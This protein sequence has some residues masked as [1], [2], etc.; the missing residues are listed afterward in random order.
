MIWHIFKKDWKLLWKFAAMMAI[1]QWANAVV[2]VKL[3][4]FAES[5]ALRNL[6]QLLVMAMLAG[7]PFLIA[8]VVHQDPIPGVRQDW[9]VRPIRRKDLLL[10]KFLFVVLAVHG[11]MLI[12]DLGRCLAFGFSFGAS[13]GAAASHGLFVLLAFSVPLF[14][15]AALTRNT[16]EAITAGLIVFLSFAAFALI[17]NGH[18]ILLLSGLSWIEATARIL[19]ALA[20]GAAIL[21]V[22]YFRR[23]TFAARGL[24]AAT[25]LVAFMTFFL[26]WN[27]AFAIEQRMSPDPA[28]GSTIAV[29]FDPSM[30]RF[31]RSASMYSGG[32]LAVVFLPLR[33]ENLPVGSVLLSDRAEVRGH[34]GSEL[35][36][37]IASLILRQEASGGTPAAAHLVVNIPAD[38][39]QGMQDQPGEVE[40]RLSLT[41]FR[42]AGLHTIPALNGRLHAPDL[43][44]CFTKMNNAETAIRLGCVPLEDRP[45][46]AT[47]RLEHI[48]SGRSNPPQFQCQGSYAPFYDTLFVE[49][50]ATG[51]IPFRDLSGLA[52]YPVDGSQLAESHVVIETFQPVDHFTRTVVIPSLRLKDW[53]AQ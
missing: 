8:A 46:C 33:F 45:S 35:S 40:I 9:L 4:P 50:A 43:G 29:A 10:A 48:P 17:M 44:S 42:S 39:Y 24:A 13:L 2:L 31:Q 7:I 37:R 25:L 1:V 21:G 20:G 47:A 16:M 28:A 26:P 52:K 22:Q 12:A 19:V 41:L 6:F 5:V 3:N 15:F 11:P 23:Q 38:R 32:E 30:G 49:P 27:T 14:A 51:N 36:E 34:D 18:Q 53:T